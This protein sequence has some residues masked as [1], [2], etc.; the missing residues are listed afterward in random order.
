MYHTRIMSISGI[1]V[2]VRARVLPTGLVGPFSDPG[3]VTHAG[4]I[5]GQ[6]PY[7]EWSPGSLFWELGVWPATLAD[8]NTCKADND[9]SAVGCPREE[10]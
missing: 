4:Q 10:K 7:K 3:K 2:I 9:Q 8:T 6:R 1:P 5:K